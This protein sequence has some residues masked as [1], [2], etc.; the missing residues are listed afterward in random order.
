MISRRKVL[1]GTAA[2]GGAWA[3]GSGATSAQTPRP[4]RLAPVVDGKTALSPDEALELLIEGN[5]NFLNDV[6][7]D[8]SSRLLR[9][10][11]NRAFRSLI[12]AHGL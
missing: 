1:A 2:A 10:P 8:R 12:I 11:Q 5:R 4:A 7:S 6:P 9:P 3:A